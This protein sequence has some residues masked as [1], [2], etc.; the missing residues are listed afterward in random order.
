M[1]P[2]VLTLLDLWFLRG[3]QLFFLEH[4]ACSYAN[5]WQDV[6]MMI[7]QA[8]QF[9]ADQIFQLGVSC[10]EWLFSGGLRICGAPQ[11]LLPYYL[12]V[13]EWKHHSLQRLDNRVLQLVR[14]DLQTLSVLAL[15][16]FPWKQHLESKIWALRDECYHH[17]FLQQQYKSMLMEDNQELEEII[18]PPLEWEGKN[19][20]FSVRLSW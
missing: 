3:H 20:Q 1:T 10:P 12:S 15:P 5:A 8:G 7:H 17:K 19:H 4:L 6:K 13:M 11:L 18:R 2:P 9:P 14:H 16:A